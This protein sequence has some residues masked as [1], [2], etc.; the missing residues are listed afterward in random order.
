MTRDMLLKEFP[1]NDQNGLLSA[2]GFAEKS[3]LTSDEFRARDADAKKLGFVSATE[4]DE[5]LELLRAKRE[6]RIRE[7]STADFEQPKSGGYAGQTTSP[8]GALSEDGNEPTSQPRDTDRSQTAD[9]EESSPDPLRKREMTMLPVLRRINKRIHDKGKP[10]TSEA[11]DGA[12]HERPEDDDDAIPAP[13][14]YSKI[15]AH[16]EARNA[17]EIAQLER[18]QELLNTSISL[19]RYS[20]GWFL[21]LL[22]LEC[23]ASSE[24]NANG[25]T[26]SISF[27]NIEKD[28]VSSKTIILKEPSRFIPQSVEELSGVRVDLQL[29]DGRTGVLHVE[30]F[31]AKEFSLLGKLKS[32]DEL[33]G[34]DL[35]KVVE[36][37]I[38]VQN[39]SFLLRELLNRFREL[40]F[41]D[42]YDMKAN[43]TP[44]IEFVFG[45]PGTGKT[46]HL[47]A[48]VLIP[49]MRGTENS[50]VL[51]LT[52]T[53][54]AADVLTTRI[55]DEMG[56]DS[57]FRNWLVRFGTSADERIEKEGVF[58]SF[59]H[60]QHRCALRL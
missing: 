28:A 6:G 58:R 11:S 26:I 32:I 1:Y 18:Q 31:T 7:V 46:T 14:D 44:R 25:K 39:P 35:S 42:H 45:P 47:A 20:Y 2:I 19:P 37:R 43:L 34:T 55:I 16:A 9:V 33:T 27:G 41:D 13:V 30:S 49:L 36:A 22:E 8:I 23:M 57:S 40:R 51:I 4:I 48:N 3:K 12:K 52:P 50:K 38:E 60:R 24:K 5:A 15:I 56:S 17:T 29:D 53:N 21:A 54:K 10:S 59:C